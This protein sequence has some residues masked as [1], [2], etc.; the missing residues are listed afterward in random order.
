VLMTS[1]G[2]DNLARGSR[3]PPTSVIAVASPPLA[4]SPL[5]A[6]ASDIP[7]PRVLHHH[8]NLFSSSTRQLLHTFPV[9]KMPPSRTPS[10]STQI[11]NT[12][13]KPPSFTNARSNSG[14]SAGGRKSTSKTAS[15][16]KKNPAHRLQLPDSDSDDVVEHLSS[17]ANDDGDSGED[18]LEEVDES[19]LSAARHKGPTAKRSNPNATTALLEGSNAPA[20]PPKLLTRMLHDGFE[21]AN[22][23]IGKDAMGVIGM[24]FETFVREALARAAAERRAVPNQGGIGDDFLQVRFELRLFSASVVSPA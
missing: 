11:R 8:R 18:D 17:S 10:G 19:E 6:D 1:R 21:D 14:S 13:F 20:I 15:K 9:A 5:S 2:V 7:P 24:Y 22:T 4:A 12:K 23:R 16:H 3:D